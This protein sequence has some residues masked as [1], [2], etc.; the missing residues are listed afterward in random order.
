VLEPG[1]PADLTPAGYSIS[2]VFDLTPLTQIS[3]NQD[4]QLDEQSARAASPLYWKVPPGRVLDAV[5]GGTESSEFLRQ[6]K[7]IADAWQGKA[8]TRYEEVPGANHFTVI[9]PLAET[10][11]AMT[12][13][14]VELANKVQAEK[15]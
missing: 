6:S 4:L 12:A 1:A 13:R 8:E 3:V 9:A 11:S 5:V 10:D 14:V 15:L 2:G 7:T